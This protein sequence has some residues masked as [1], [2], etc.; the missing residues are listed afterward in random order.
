M[1]DTLPN[2]AVLLHD[3]RAR[4]GYSRAQLAALTRVPLTFITAIEEDD[5]AALPSTV[6]CR[7]FLQIIAKH[8]D[9]DELLA[10][11]TASTVTA[12]PTT[13]LPLPTNTMLQHYSL[14]TRTARTRRNY[15]LLGASLI[16]LLSG[17]MALMLL[18]PQ[19]D[20][21]L[22]TVASNTAADI[23]PSKPIPDLPTTSS[24]PPLTVQQRL[25]LQVA[26]PLRIKLALDAEPARE[27][28]L[29]PQRYLFEFQQQAWLQ[30]PDTA[31]V[32]IWFNDE[33]L[34][35]LQRGGQQR[36]LVFKAAPT[37]ARADNAGH[38]L[39]R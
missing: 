38:H 31:A 7:G 8:L 22:P 29:L 16:V 6:F 32:E 4:R 15:K 28:L 20:S 30:I 35:N 12:T 33:P 11:Y 13:T 18:W 34:G 17:G 24:V 1:T 23:K 14:G 5:R 10:A 2:L 27:Q 21:K 25:R 39:Q 37:V 19:A 26:R 9:A 3:A 36:T